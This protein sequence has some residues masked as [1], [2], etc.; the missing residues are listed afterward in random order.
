MIHV[1]PLDEESM[2]DLTEAGT[3]CQC[4]PRVYWS[5]AEPI[6]VHRSRDGR[7]YIEDAEEIINGSGSLPNSQEPG[8]E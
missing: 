2:H 5:E 8:V 1:Y 3:T 6:V 4:S 7:E